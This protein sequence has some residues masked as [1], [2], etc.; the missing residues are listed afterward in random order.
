MIKVDQYIEIILIVAIQLFFGLK[1]FFICYRGI[2]KKTG[3]E[4]RRILRSSVISEG[5]A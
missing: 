4:I 5:T 2:A 1:R 3:R